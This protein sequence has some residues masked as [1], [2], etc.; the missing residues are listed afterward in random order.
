MDKEVQ[1][2]PLPEVTNS[3]TALGSDVAAPMAQR[4]DNLLPVPES[5]LLH[6]ALAHSS[7]VFA[8]VSSFN[9]MNDSVKKNLPSPN[10]KLP[11][12]KRSRIVYEGKTCVREFITQ[13]EE[14]FL[15]KNFDEFLL[16]GSFSDLL[17][18]SAAKWFRANRANIASWLDLKV[19]LL[20][21]FDKLEHDYFLE[22]ELRTRKQRT[23]E[24]LPDFITELVDMASRLT[25]PI[26]ESVIITITKHNMLPIYT[27]YVVGRSISS[28]DSFLSLGK[29]L[30]VFVSR[31]PLVKEV[32]KPS[33]FERVQSSVVHTNT[34]QP[35]S[36]VCLKCKTAGHTYRDCPAIP[37]M[38]CFKCQKLGVITKFC[39][40]C[41]SEKV[42]STNSKN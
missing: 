11:D 3:N 1:F 16:V 36:I 8:P 26:A 41:N 15:Y 4:S 6:G 37:G 32:P 28:L 12:L 34:V 30:E 18:G 33:R 40:V 42:N 2:P 20:R 21:R 17:S 7:S 13:V 39:D 35:D 10:T 9:T 14:Y 23:N 5:F 25:T 38:I 29:E 19:A 27:P 24:S 22:Y 31:K